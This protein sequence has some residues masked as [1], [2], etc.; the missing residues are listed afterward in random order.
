M[1]SSATMPNSDADRIGHL[2]RHHGDR[3][4]HRMAGAQAAHDDVERVGELRA[5]LLLPPAALELEHQTAAAAC[6]RTARTPSASSRSPRITIARPN[7]NS[8]PHRDVDRE[9]A[10]AER[11]ARLQDQ[12]VERDQR[13]PVVAARLRPALAAQ[14]HQH[15]L[16]V[17]LVVHQPQA[18]VD[19]LAVGAR[20]EEQQI[21]AFDEQPGRERREQID[22]ID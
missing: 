21:D 17:G 19:V 2:A 6:S 12:P 14:L 10:D 4:R 8:A 18:A 15:A 5:E 13:Q 22:H 11:Q 1:I 9:L 7:A 16:A 20:V 3:D